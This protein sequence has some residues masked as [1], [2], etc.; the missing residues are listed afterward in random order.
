ML[1]GGP[2]FHFSSVVLFCLF[3]SIRA[4]PFE[5]RD[6]N[7]VYNITGYDFAPNHS[8]DPFPPYPD[9]K[10]DKGNPIDPKSV[11]GTRLFGW[12]GCDVNEQKIIVESYNDF[13][14]LAQQKE[15]YDNIDWT[16]KSATE[17]WGASKGKKA[18]SDDTKKQIKRRS[19]SSRGKSGPNATYCRNL[20][21]CPAS[22]QLRLVLAA[23][24]VLWETTL[25]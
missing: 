23:S 11:R 10:D 16:D 12:T 17:F 21:S 14:K 25:D 3:S 2:A 9:L 8:K 7:S 6:T 15:V 18:I 24:V 13:Y 19:K 5:E 4:V 22:L 1:L 20:P